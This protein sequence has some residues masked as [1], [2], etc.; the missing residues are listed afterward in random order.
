[1][2]AAPAL[3]SAPP[4]L[5]P[6]NSPEGCRRA[7]R[8]RACTVR[9]NALFVNLSHAELDRI[10]WRVPEMV[11]P[12]GDALYHHADTPG[13]IFIIRSGLVKLE[14]YLPDGSYRIVRLARR[15]DLLALEGL[16][17]SPCDHTAIALADTEVCKVPH[18][19]VHQVMAHQPWISTQMLRH[20]H[21]AL[22]K[23]DGWLAQ[24]SLGA[25]RQRV[26]R[27]LVDLHDAASDDHGAITIPNRDDVGAILGLTKETT[28]RLIA[29]FHRAGFLTKIDQQRATI[30]RAPLD[31]I[32]QGA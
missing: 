2:S 14:T 9:Q 31:A 8:C 28:S 18:E 19:V 11:I 7:E 26:A 6:Q 17:S 27:F 5:D 3:R 4:D 21:Q 24:Y 22:Q 25:G 23:A 13:H 12:A 10:A 32:A 15:S 1:M 30:Q 16:L 20:W 29:E